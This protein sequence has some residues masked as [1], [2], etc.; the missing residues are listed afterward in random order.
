MAT[1]ASDELKTRIVGELDATLKLIDET[2]RRSVRA[3]IPGP[4]WLRAARGC[5][6]LAEMDWSANFYK[7]AATAILQSAQDDGRR[8]GFYAPLALLAIGAAWMSGDRDVLATVGSTIDEAC[9]SMIANTE[10]TPEPLVAASLH[11]TRIRVAWF[12]GRGESIQRLMPDLDRAVRGLDKWGE[13]YLEA[14]RDIHSITVF[15]TL[16]AQKPDPIKACIQKYNEYLVSQ[17]AKSPTITELVDEEFIS[18]ASAIQ[19]LGI[20]LARVTLPIVPGKF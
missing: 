18:F 1:S 3:V 6:L 13:W 5:W 20:E 11:L 14:E 17:Q 8:Q 16:L 2:Q 4:V 9:R 12:Q 10:M 19:D 15:R 7:R